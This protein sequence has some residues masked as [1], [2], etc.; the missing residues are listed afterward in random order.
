MKIKLYVDDLRD[1]PEGFVVARSFQEALYFFSHYEIELLSLDHDLGEDE[2]GNI[3]PSGYDLVKHIGEYGL[4]ADT[5][6]IHTDNPVGRENMHSSLLS[7]KRHSLID[8]DTDVYRYNVVPNVYSYYTPENKKMFDL[9]M[10]ALK[11]N[12]AEP[13]LIR[14]Y[15]RHVIEV[16]N[17]PHGG[18]LSPE[19]FA[20]AILYKEKT[21]S[22]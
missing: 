10:E 2:K 8:P 3:L 7:F 5:I 20:E 12:D 4:K 22:S 13:L 1:C 14:K 9:I 15:E 6:Y 16:L 11:E 17:M 18:S 21:E 19:E